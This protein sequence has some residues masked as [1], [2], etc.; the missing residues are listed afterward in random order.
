MPYRP[1]HLIV[2]WTVGLLIAG[3]VLDAATGLIDLIVTL[4]YPHFYDMTST[5]PM[6]PGEEAVALIGLGVGLLMVLLYIPTVVMFCVWLF[7]MSKNARALGAQGMKHSAG[8]AVGS[9]F[10]PILNLFR[11]YQATAEIEKASDPHAGPT[12]W[13]HTSGSGKVGLWWGFWLTSG[14]ISQIAF[15]MSTSSDPD[16]AQASSV[17]GVFS[18]AVNILSAW[19]AIR[20]IRHLHDLQETKV[21]VQPQAVQST[22]LGC[23]Y[24]LRGTPGVACPECG[25]P[26]PGRGEWDTEHAPPDPNTEWSPLD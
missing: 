9:F 25:T 15:R 24:D 16:I 13:S 17:V 22:C 21:R 4:K 7:R 5:A 23:G 8:W 11:P 10:V 19:A 3:M 20:V 26:I 6:Q 2:G 1:A 14:F 12:N 18:S